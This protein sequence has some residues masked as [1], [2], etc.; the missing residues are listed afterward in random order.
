MA[1][2]KKLAQIPS[3]VDARIILD[4]II[5]NSFWTQRNLES[6]K[7]TKFLKTNLLS[8]E[9][10]KVGELTPADVSEE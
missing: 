1:N 2:Y 10:E 5:I 7:L 8:T 6:A 9:F 3:L 4:G